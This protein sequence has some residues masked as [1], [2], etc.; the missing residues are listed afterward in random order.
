MVR[1]EIRPE[2]KLDDLEGGDCLVD[3]DVDES[4]L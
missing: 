4:I 1:V 2:F 3:L